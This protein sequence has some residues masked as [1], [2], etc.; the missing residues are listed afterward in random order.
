MKDWIHPNTIVGS[1]AEGNRYFQREKIEDKLWREIRKGNH[2]LFSAPRRVGKSSIMK[3]V[4]ENPKKDYICSYQNI[5]SDDSS[6]DFYKRLF[7]LAMFEIKGISKVWK[8][9]ESWRKTLEI[10][11]VTTTGVT[12]TR[13]EIDYKD[14]FLALLGQLKGADLKIVLLLDEFPDVLKNI[15]KNESPKIA[16]DILQTLRSLRHNDQFRGHFI[17]VL[18]GS[19]GLD[20]VVK[21]IDRLAVINDLHEQNLPALT[22]TEA[23][24][25]ISHLVDGATMEI[26]AACSQYLLDKLKQPIPFFIQLFIEQCNDLLYDAQRTQLTTEDIDT[27]WETILREHKHFADWD[28]RLQEYFPDAYPFLNE[29]LSHCAH[30]E[31]ISIQV[32]YDLGAKHKQGLSYKGLIDDVLIKDGYLQQTEL[33]FKFVSPILRDWWQ[34]RH[35]LLPKQKRN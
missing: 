4:A 8:K 6:R 15:A 18:A 7:E 14:S 30:S 3:Y 10:S 26:D 35:P 17:L 20:H 12:F 33:N 23:T 16:R 29:V 11:D 31:S 32:I 34:N 2:I 22:E 5:S 13:K 25:F 1:T 28:E 21:S 9:L 24:D 27:I 19:I